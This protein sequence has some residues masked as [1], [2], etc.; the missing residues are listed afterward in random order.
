[1]TQTFSISRTYIYRYI[2]KETVN[3]AA[4]LVLKMW[5]MAAMSVPNRPSPRFIDWL[6]FIPCQV[7]IKFLAYNYW[8]MQEETAIHYQEKKLISVLKSYSIFYNLFV[9]RE[10]SKLPLSFSLFR[11]RPLVSPWKRQTQKIWPYNCSGS[12][13]VYN[14]LWGLTKGIWRNKQN[15]RSVFKNLASRKHKKEQTKPH[16]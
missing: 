11:K 14:W 16:K 10:N 5:I 2:W 4:L 3:S 12:I 6:G 13:Y 8:D 15:S 9:F 1:M 7:H